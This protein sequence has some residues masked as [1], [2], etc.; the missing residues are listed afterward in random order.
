MLVQF[1][2]AGTFGSY[3]HKAYYYTKK[4]GGGL[5]GKLRYLLSYVFIPMNVIKYSYP[6]IYRHKI[7]LPL[8]PLDRIVK[9]LTVY[10]ARTKATLRALIKDKS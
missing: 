6:F 10:R 8:V 2:D 5:K 4:Y 3:R 1:L 9:G 7:L